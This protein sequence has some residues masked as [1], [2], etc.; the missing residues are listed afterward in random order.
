MKLWCL[1]GN[2]QLPTVWNIF[3][4][5]WRV[6]NAEGESAPIQLCRLNLWQTTPPD[7]ESWTTAFCDKVQRHSDESPG[8]P[9]WLMG[10]SWGGRLAMHA[11]LKNPELWTGVILI[12]AHP[13]YTTAREK[14]KQLA[15][16]AAWAQRFRNESWND[17][18]QAWD[19]LPVFSGSLTNP[20]QP[21][22]VFSREH[23]AFC[24]EAYSKGKQ[25]FLL[26][27]LSRLQNPP[28]LFISG[29]RDNKYKKIGAQL[30]LACPAI[31]HIAI[32]NAGHRTPWEN[33]EGF[34][35]KI[36]VFL[37]TTS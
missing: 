8:S 7:F 15:W 11:L 31:Q 34:S 25:E 26:P 2:L 14:E 23:V 13:G 35:E 6:T 30:S 3:E 18:L 33:P 20:R 4:D 16:D 36:Q 22:H 17:T 24:L 32:P 29:E 12:G 27:A 37:D 19:A 1:H 10:Y 21:E 5:T 28:V 9:Q